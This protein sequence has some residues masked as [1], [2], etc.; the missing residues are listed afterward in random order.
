MA[1]PAAGLTLDDKRR[2]T[3]TLLRAG[4]DIHALNTGENILGGQGGA[5][6]RQRPGP[7]AAPS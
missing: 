5:A 3:A 2:T 7:R 6:L 4:A 1:V